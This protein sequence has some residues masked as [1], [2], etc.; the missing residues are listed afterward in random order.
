MRALKAKSLTNITLALDNPT[1]E[2]ITAAVEGAILGD[3]EPDHLKTD[4]KKT[5]K[6]LG[7]FCLLG[8]A[9]L[10]PA[11]DRDACSPRRRISR[12]ISLMSQLTC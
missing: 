6:R 7:S 2:Q 1:E 5:E 4:P 12:G 11:L 3:Y 9:T 10:Q 8:P